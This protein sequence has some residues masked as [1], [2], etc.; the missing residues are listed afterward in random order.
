MWGERLDGLADDIFGL[1]DA[2]AES[3]IAALGKRYELSRP[4]YRQAPTET[5]LN[6]YDFY[7]LGQFYERERNRESLERALAMYRRAIDT[8]PLLPDGHRGVASVSLLLTY[9]GEL[10]LS[11]AED[12]ALHHLEQA[13]QL[14]PGDG[15][16]YAVMGLARYLQ[17]EYGPAEEMLQRA[18]EINVN[19]AMAWMWLAMAVEMEGK[20]RQAVEYYRRAARLEP[21]STVVKTNLA[22]ALQSSGQPEQA[23]GVLDSIKDV[24][25]TSVQY[26]R[27]RSDLL[28]QN[29][30]LMGAYG[31]VRR[32]LELDPADAMATAQT[33]LV[34]EDLGRLEKRRKLFDQ[35]LERGLNGK[36]GALRIMEEIYIRLDPE[37][38][39][40][41]D[42]MISLLFPDDRRMAQ[43]RWRTRAAFR[44]LSAAYA[45]RYDKAIALFESVWRGG[46]Y[47][48]VSTDFDLLYCTAAVYSQ[49]ARGDGQAGA[50]ALVECEQALKRARELGWDSQWI[51][52]TAAQIAALGGRHEQA[53]RRLE[54]LYERGFN[55]TGL[56]E[57]D[58]VFGVTRQNPG[59]P[60]VLTQMKQ[61][62]A[63]AWAEIEQR[64]ASEGL[65]SITGQ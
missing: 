29:G 28:L 20:L 31:H 4:S 19:D 41:A 65:L 21:L 55:G 9:Y 18:L 22:S 7:L 27:V 11:Q 47:A 59:F 45:G 43:I 3:V 2:V 44:E 15:A 62:A 64:G 30:E 48:I 38:K 50:D 52:Y 1:Q 51:D 57:N 23:F 17:G 10:S 34:L 32:A 12:I 63:S 25:A 35:I 16:N 39:S 60:A 6:A 24:G 37:G 53:I 33:A 56:V 13:L 42:R 14:D 8:D 54:S 40:R 61:R 58:P 36:A 26:N 49:Q 46:D 5:I